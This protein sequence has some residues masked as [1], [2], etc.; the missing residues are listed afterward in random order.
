M[1]KMF[2][3][4]AMLIAT[5]GV[6]AQKS[7]IRDARDYL[8]D[9][10]YKKAL[11]VI[12][13]A[14]NNEDTRN[15]PEAWFLRG[16]AY[17]QQAIDST[18]NAPGAA[19]ESYTSMMKAVSLKPDYGP[20]I[21][22]GLYS[23]ALLAFNAGVAAYKDNPAEA[24]DK[25]MRTVEIYNIGNGKRFIGDKGFTE[26]VASAKANAA[27]S[28]INAKKDP[29]ALVLL[30]DLKANAG[31]KDSNIYQSLIEIYQRQK[32]DGPLLAAISDARRQFPSSQLFRNLELNYYIQKGQSD[33]L[34]GKLEEAVKGDP[35][36]PELL[37]NLANVYERAAFP[38]DEKGAYL[39][40]PANFN[41]LFAKGEA[42][43]QKA[44]AVSPNNPDYNYNL[45]VLYYETAT[46]ITKQM[47][48]I[49]GMT[50][51]EQK[52]YDA[53]LAQRDAQF[54]K[55]LPYFE[56]AYSVL[57]ARSGSLDNSEKITYQNAMIGLREIYSRRNNKVKT[58][59]LKA[60]LDAMRR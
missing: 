17:L 2:L 23:N 45:G 40:K 12:N 11:V 36:N 50:P 52:Q 58:D 21:N 38:K 32:A 39:S 15:N 48:A 5:G 22:N 10:N 31:A 1:K 27:Y 37:F 6:W 25:F 47:N 26:L 16:M 8:S 57:D 33:V 44:L 43:Y 60:K 9:Q 3:I 46:E 42:T 55:A 30:N 28:A 49:K 19:N 56:K 18:A 51:A 34:L 41:D 14:V 53:L 13:E 59:E 7:R 35:N 20:E 24:Y 29:E 54:S 4:G